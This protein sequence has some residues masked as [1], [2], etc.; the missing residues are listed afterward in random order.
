M[1]NLVN[2]QLNLIFTQ[3]ISRYLLAKNYLLLYKK[4]RP[5]QGQFGDLARGSQDG[6]TT[7]LDLVGYIYV[8]CS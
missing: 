4:Q 7:S 5:I 3:F 2:Q 8:V 6:D 1:I